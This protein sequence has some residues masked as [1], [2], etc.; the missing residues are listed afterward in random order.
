MDLQN[1]IN[2]HEDY[3]SIFK[4]NNLKLKFFHKKYCL[5]TSDYNNPLTYDNNLFLVIH[6]LP[7]VENLLRIIR[8]KQKKETHKFYIEQAVN[9]QPGSARGTRSFLLKINKNERLFS[10]KKQDN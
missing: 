9:R 8:Q 1:F 5:V 10:E 3:L 2:T 6:K 7:Y 4:E